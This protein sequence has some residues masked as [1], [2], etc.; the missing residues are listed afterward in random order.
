LDALGAPSVAGT[1]ALRPGEKTGTDF[2]GLSS[3]LSQEGRN[4]IGRLLERSATGAFV[5]W[6]PETVHAIAPPFPIT[7]SHAWPG[8]NVDPLRTILTA[9]PT[10]GVALVRLGGYAV[11]V[12]QN[13]TLIGSKSGTGHVHGRHKA[14]GWSQQRFARRR[15]GQARQLFDR[16]CEVAREQFEAAEQAG[17]RLDYVLLGGDRHTLRQ[18]RERCPWLERYGE[19]VLGRVLAVDQ[20]NHKALEGITTEVW[21]SEAV[22]VVTSR[23]E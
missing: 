21:K 23:G 5:F 2:A 4:A 3:A 11:G 16:V 18:F 6:S 12:F 9:A 7:Q 19:R 13:E 8:W 15:E 20:P 17:A 1:L 22:S 10:Y 14:G